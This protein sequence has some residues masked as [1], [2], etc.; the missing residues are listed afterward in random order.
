M[1]R[2]GLE[3]Y[4]DTMRKNSAEVAG[5]YMQE[6]PM[7][8]AIDAIDWTGLK[9][10]SSDQVAMITLPSVKGLRDMANDVFLDIL[11][12]TSPKSKYRIAELVVQL[13]NEKYREYK[14]A[15]PKFTGRVSLFGH[16]LGS[17]IAFDILS[18]QK[19]VRGQ[20]MAEGV[21][22]EVD[23]MR[24]GWRWPQLDFDVDNLFAVGSPLA[25]FCTV[26]GDIQ[27]KEWPHVPG[28]G[29]TFPGGAKLFN[30][31]HPAD[32][33]AYR[34]EPLIDP[35]ASE[36]APGVV[37]VRGEKRKD[38]EEGARPGR[39]D[40]VLQNVSS[41]GYSQLIGGL[42]FS[43][44]WCYWEN[45]DTML[46]LL[47]TIDK[48]QMDYDFFETEA[49]KSWLRE[50]EKLMQKASQDDSHGDA[51]LEGAAAHGALPTT[52]FGEPHVAPAVHK[53]PQPKLRKDSSRGHIEA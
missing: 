18:K 32:P 44:H 30:I 14:A 6:R 15:Y 4:I 53:A 16:S 41:E 7:M 12:Y 20:G 8:M 37:P 27:S 5:K 1:T 24:S 26:R 51:F 9:R 40:F 17:I 28:G 48:Q 38:K 50:C 10:T 35:K 33:I 3:Q 31:Y 19:K 43:T 52:R 2:A 22:G 13:L 21:V 42:T 46:F 47:E 25:C 34:F 23:S 29:Y 36:E 45:R 49:G 39:I 11:Y